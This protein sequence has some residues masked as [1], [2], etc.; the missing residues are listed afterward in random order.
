M[1]PF[2]D[3]IKSDDDLWKIVTWI[4]SLGATKGASK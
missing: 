2:K 1:P 4:K 3:I